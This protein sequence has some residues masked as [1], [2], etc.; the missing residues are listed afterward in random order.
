[1]STRAHIRRMAKTQQRLARKNVT[2]VLGEDSPDRT[3]FRK[4]HPLKEFLPT[5]KAVV[6]AYKDKEVKESQNRKSATIEMDF[7]KSAH[8]LPPRQEAQTK[9]LAAIYDTPELQPEVPTKKAR[10]RKKG[11]KECNAVA[12]ES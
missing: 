6:E 12:G 3:E 9:I 10:P 7:T 11:V 5:A 2:T 1:M 8:E 4:Q